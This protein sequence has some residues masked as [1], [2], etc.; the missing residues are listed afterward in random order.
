LR[1]RLRREGERE[2]GDEVTVTSC[3]S[4]PGLRGKKGGKKKENTAMALISHFL[5]E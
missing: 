5:K 1:K 2:K 3:S 4:T